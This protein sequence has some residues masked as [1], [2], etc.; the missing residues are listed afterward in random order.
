MI[1]LMIQEHG[2][3]VSNPLMNTY[4]PDDLEKTLPF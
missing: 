4:M 3:D 1:N 2:L